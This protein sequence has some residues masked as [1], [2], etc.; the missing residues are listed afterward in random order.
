MATFN[1]E[2]FN[3]KIYLVFQ[4]VFISIYLNA[5]SELLINLANGNGLAELP[6]RQFVVAGNDNNFLTLVSSGGDISILEFDSCGLLQ[7]SRLFET[8]FDCIQ[9]VDISESDDEFFLLFRNCSRF[10][11]V[12]LA[13][14][15]KSFGLLWCKTFKIGEGREPY[16]VDINSKGNVLVSVAGNELNGAKPWLLYFGNDGNH[17]WS[18][19]VEIADDIITAVLSDDDRILLSIEDKVAQFDITPDMI[20]SKKVVAD[21]FFDDFKTTGYAPV[22]MDN[23]YII[24]LRSHDVNNYLLKMDKNGEVLV[25]SSPFAFTPDATTYY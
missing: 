4:Y 11:E 17:V 13:R 6:S 18:L 22:K 2:F 23:F 9:L 24:S 3:L 1:R 8:G 14:L 25:N 20:W 5:Q 15:K 21:P 16:M 10:D 12:G 19:E 7:K